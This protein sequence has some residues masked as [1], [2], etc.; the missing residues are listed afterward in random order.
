[1]HLIKRHWLNTGCGI[2]QKSLP[3]RS[4]QVPSR[5]ALSWLCISL[6]LNLI[7]SP[8][9]SRVHSFPLLG[10]VFEDPRLGW[11]EG[12]VW[13][14]QSQA[15][16]GVIGTSSVTQYPEPKDWGQGWGASLL[17]CWQGEAEEEEWVSSSLLPGYWRVGAPKPALDSSPLTRPG[18]AGRGRCSAAGSKLSDHR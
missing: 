14:A 10:S 9:Q 1:M 13:T 18:S 3:W 16:V 8:L 12:A 7:G 17:L 11:R 6:S 15:S 2:P 5:S 4:P